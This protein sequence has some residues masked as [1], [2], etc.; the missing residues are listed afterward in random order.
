MKNLF[1]L[2]GF[3][4]VSSYAQIVPVGESLPLN[5][6]DSSFV[7][8]LSSSLEIDAPWREIT[9]LVFKYCEGSMIITYVAPKQELIVCIKDYELDD[10][11]VVENGEVILYDED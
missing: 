1:L 3:F 11:Y 5:K 6:E 7:K 2:I 9:S 10:F 8:H 4:C